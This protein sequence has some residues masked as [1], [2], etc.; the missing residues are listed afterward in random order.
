MEEVNKLNVMHGIKKNVSKVCKDNNINFIFIQRYK[1]LKI[2][3]Y[4]PGKDDLI[5]KLFDKFMEVTE[6]RRKKK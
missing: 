4:K 2:A 3:A 5:R 6:K 1:D